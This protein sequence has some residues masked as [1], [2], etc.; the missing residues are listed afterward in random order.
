MG[1]AYTT[2]RA[3]IIV[4]THSDGQSDLAGTY[5]LLLAANNIPSPMS[6]PNTVESTDFED[7]TQTFEMGVKTADA[8]EVTGNLTKANFDY[9]Q[10]LEGQELDIINL[11]GT[12][13]IG[14]V[15]KIARQGKI[16]ASIGDAGGVDEILSITATIVPSTSA[17]TVTD[18]Y[19]VVDNHDGTFTVTATGT[20]KSIA[21]DKATATIEVGAV[22]ALTATTVPAGAAVTWTS[23]DDTKASVDSHGIVRG[24]AAGSATITATNDSVSATC[25]VTVSAGA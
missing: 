20:A 10:S 15:A 24:V 21:L 3:R 19:T 7:D 4:K 22:L 2:Y 6:A 16:S 5:R 12:D 9:V 11:Y 1:K 17:A 23:S 13:G 18:N 14:G 8:Q 25:T